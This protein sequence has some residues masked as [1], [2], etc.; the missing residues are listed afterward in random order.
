MNAHFTDETFEK[1]D[2]TTTP[3]PKGEYDN[4]R[5]VQCNFADANLSHYKF[6]ECSFDNCN[7]SM[8]NT[9]ET[10]LRDIKF[11]G[12]KMLGIHFE[13]C[14]EFLFR[15]SFDNCLLNFSS[16]Y[17]RNLKKAVFKNCSLRETDFTEADLS[18]AVFE[19]CDLAMAA[20]ENA[21]L[22]KADLR[23]A[24]NYSIDPMKNRIK[25]ARF[26]MEGIA[27]LLNQWD[28]EIE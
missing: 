8:I 2:Y 6:S 23:S 19:N 26:S 16:F 13:K 10:A 25:K 15:V 12:C 3:L 5:F 18:G 7:L 1:Q 21:N 11:K 17:K 24:Y 14:N 4:C 9:T 22:E 28:I 27:G 20:F